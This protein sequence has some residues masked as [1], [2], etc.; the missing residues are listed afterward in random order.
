[1]RTAVLLLL[2]ALAL[3]AQIIPGPRWFR[4]ASGMLGL[5]PAN[6]S[7]REMER[8]ERYLYFGVP[9]CG[10][11]AAQQYAANAALARSMGPYLAAVGANAV[12]PQARVAALRVA[13]A[14]SSFPCAYQGKHL[15]V[16]LEP[17][18]Q[19][20]DAPFA[21]HAPD[22]GRVPDEEQETA[23]DLVVRYD[24]SAARSATTWK[25]AEQ[26]RLNLGTRGMG[27]NAATATAMGRLGPLYDEAAAALKA[28]KWDD[29]L[30]TLQA[31][32]ATTQKIA[33]VAGK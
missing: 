30:S 2:G 28:H 24:T 26:I 8:L 14:F 12:D 9:Y 13:T 17:P 4:S 10:A 3:P 21:V 31:A 23:A 32:E 25:N 15:P 5:P 20:G 7:A 33:T 1:M 16:M 27:L 18:P 19:P 6:A 29:A 11:L 22:L